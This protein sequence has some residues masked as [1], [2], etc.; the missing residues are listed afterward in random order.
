MKIGDTEL[1]ASDTFHMGYTKPAGMHVAV[2]VDSVA[3]AE[4]IFKALSAGGDVTMKMEETFFAHRFG[5]VV[6][7]FGTPWMVVNS[8][9][10]G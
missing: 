8:K 9:P 3:E 2:N 10:M 4:R 7:R 6:D 1:M 5:Q